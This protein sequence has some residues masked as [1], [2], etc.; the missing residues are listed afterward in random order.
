MREAGG[1]EIQPVALMTL[2]AYMDLWAIPKE[3]IYAFH[4]LPIGSVGPPM[5][6]GRTQWCVYR[7]LDKRVGDM[8]DFPAVRESYLQQVEQ[9]KKFQARQRWLEEFK[10]AANIT[11]N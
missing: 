4:N 2:E 6:F 9:K 1:H 7:L 10:R 5:P 3:Q 11:R 8:A